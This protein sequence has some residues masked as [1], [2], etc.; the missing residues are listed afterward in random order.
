M[1]PQQ[2]C[3]ERT[4]GAG[5]SFFYAFIFLPE[6]QRRAM[7]ALYAFCREVDDIADEIRDRDVARHK[8][9]FWR[10]EIDKVFD[11]KGPD[12]PVGKELVWVRQHFPVEREPMEQMLDGMLMDVEGRPIHSDEQLDHY[13]H[14]V[15]G[16]VGLLTIAVFGYR[17]PQSRAFAETLG[18]ALQLTN[19]LRDVA[20]DARSGRIYLPQQ[21]RIEH[22]VADQDLIDGRLHDGL[23]ALLAHYRKEADAAYQ[24]ARAL[25]PE[26]DRQT[27]RASLIMGALYHRHLQ[28]LHQVAGDVW[29][30]PVT[31][32]PLYKIWIAWRAWRRETRDAKHHQPINIIG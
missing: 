26:E 22:G 4:R 15:A 20:E 23:K 24:N 27:L 32:S 8:L 11:G 9:A 18:R 1:T 19:I 10:K 2:Y 21:A 16:T 13:C 30:H 12:H 17:N 25:L 14:C 6:Q 3:E 5:S 29:R 7:M 31:F 28:K